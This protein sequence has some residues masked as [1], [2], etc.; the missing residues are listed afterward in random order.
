MKEEKQKKNSEKKKI[1]FSL[2][3]FR[4]GGSFFSGIGL[5]SSLKARLPF[6]SGIYLGGGK[7]ILVSLTA[8]AIGFLASMFL[9][10]S[11]G[12]QQIVFPA[13]GAQY[14]A[15]NMIGNPI[16]DAEFPADRSQTLQINIPAQTRLDEIILKNIS[17]GKSGLTDSFELTGTSTTDV[18]TIDELVIKNSEFPSM[19]W[20]NG[21]IYL[22]NATSS[23]IAAGHTFSPTMSSTT[24]DVVVGSGRGATSYI[25]ED[26]V[27]DRIIIR[28]STTGGDVII[29]KL[30][31]D[32]V[33]AWT[34]GFDGD[35][36]EIGT[37]TLQNVRIGDD[38]DIN[39][40][41]L[42]INSSVNA[43]TIND[44]VLE[45]PVFIR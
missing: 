33:K 14:D 8:V 11:K 36:F 23:V 20:A 9:L 39:S 45:E 12:E 3:S 4:I 24:N 30:I 21:N 22:I 44:G 27:V 2:P 13:L 31:L 26:M 37:L 35:Y 40:A 28:Q 41:D 6:P 34:G 43:N 19:D 18:L 25:A 29:G 15:P 5:P 7:L 1:S 16:V 38:G 10:I 32:G 17:L 42:I